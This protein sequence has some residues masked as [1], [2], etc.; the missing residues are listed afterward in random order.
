MV[1]W[2]LHSNTF[3]YVMVRLVFTS[4]I[5]KNILQTTY[6]C[7]WRLTVS[8]WL[9]RTY[10]YFRY[11]SS[12]QT[13]PSSPPMNSWIEQKKDTLSFL[14]FRLIFA[15]TDNSLTYCTQKLEN[16][17][18]IISTNNILVS[19]TNINQDLSKH[20]VNTTINWHLA[21]SRWQCMLVCRVTPSVYIV[22]TV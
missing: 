21:G 8:A 19:E 2:V 3:T 6:R 22:G 16:M 5:T 17:L 11:Q 13:K 12:H 9:A 1:R 10:C 18:H 7:R 4:N 15:L 20:I 14:Y